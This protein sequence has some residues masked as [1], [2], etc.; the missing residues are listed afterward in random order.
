MHDRIDLARRRTV[1]PG[2]APD[3]GAASACGRGHHRRRRS[4]PGALSRHR[5][6]HPGR[7][8]APHR[9]GVA[10]ISDRGAGLNVE[11][12]PSVRRSFSVRPVLGTGGEL[13]LGCP[14]PAIPEM[15]CRGPGPCSLPSHRQHRRRNRDRHRSRRGG[16]TSCASALTIRVTRNDDLG[17]DPVSLSGRSRMASARCRTRDGARNLAIRRNS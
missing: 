17:E 7:D 11:T 12:V 15:G 5:S 1:H 13:S 8:P 10:D 16:G 3:V 14:V 6:G 9:G 4:H 2:T